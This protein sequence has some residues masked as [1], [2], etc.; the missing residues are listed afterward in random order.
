ML[1]LLLSG[2]FLAALVGA[3]ERSRKLLGIA[4]AC[5]AVLVCIIVLVKPVQLPSLRELV[6]GTTTTVTDA[7]RS[8]D[9]AAATP[10]AAPAVSAT[11][12]ADD[13]ADAA[14]SRSTSTTAPLGANST[15]TAALG[16]SSIDSPSGQQAEVAG[17][18]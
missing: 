11:V 17:V 6:K 5:V 15:T 7:A 18:R 4:G 9:D 2:L 14:S 16:V 12:P 10:T 13:P 3:I 8:H 1:F